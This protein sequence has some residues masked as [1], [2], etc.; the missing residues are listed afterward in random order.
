VKDTGMFPKYV[1]W[2]DVLDSIGSIHRG[3]RVIPRLG[4]GSTCETFCRT[5]TRCFRFSEEQKYARLCVLWL[6]FV[7]VLVCLVLEVVEVRDVAVSWWDFG[8][9]TMAINVREV[10]APF[11]RR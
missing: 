1:Y 6:T 2:Y 7:S 10:V 11:K 5:R 3:I 4:R 8:V 9:F